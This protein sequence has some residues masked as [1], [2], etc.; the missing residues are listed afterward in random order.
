[1]REALQL[2]NMMENR[3]PIVGRIIITLQAQNLLH[4]LNMV[5]KSILSAARLNPTIH[6][7]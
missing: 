1:M 6:D 7:N 4:I 3:G 5:I 2:I